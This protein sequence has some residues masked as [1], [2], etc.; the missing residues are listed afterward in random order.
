TVCEWVPTWKWMGR[1]SRKICVEY[2]SI[3]PPCKAPRTGA[4]V[5]KWGIHGT[6]TK[7]IPTGHPRPQAQ[8]RH[9]DPIAAILGVEPGK[10]LYRGKVADVER[11]A[12]EGFLRG[13][14]RLDGMAEH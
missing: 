12:T 10:V 5:K 7:A 8:R 2:G 1:V 6:T 9:E 3:A 11:R 14:T 4:E 13:R